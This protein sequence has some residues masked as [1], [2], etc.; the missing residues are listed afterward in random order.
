MD[1]RELFN[2]IRDLVKVCEQA[3]REGRPGETRE[4]LVEIQTMITEFLG[5][6]N[7]VDDETETKEET[8]KVLGQDEQGAADQTRS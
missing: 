1:L 5:D 4:R 7:A 3:D 8:P 2:E 6:T